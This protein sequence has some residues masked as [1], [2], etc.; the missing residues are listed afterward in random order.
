M[1]VL[2]IGPEKALIPFFRALGY[3][4]WL[5]ILEWCTICADLLS[6][7]SNHWQAFGC[8][9]RLPSKNR[10]IDTKGPMRTESD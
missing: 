10:E 1:M 8:S 4:E 2:N 7:G 5:E 3:A 6:L 9:L